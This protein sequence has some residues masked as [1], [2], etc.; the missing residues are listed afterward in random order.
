MPSQYALVRRPS[1]RL[2]E[3]LVSHID[4]QP[5]D[6]G[7]ALRQWET[8]VQVLCDHGWR[9]TEVAPADDCPDAAFVEDTMVV[10]RNVALIA[11]PGAAPRR[12]ETSGARAAAEA[13]G[14][15]VNEVRAPGTL[16]GGDVLKVGDTVYVGRGGRTNADGVRQ[17]RA[18]F[19]PL[20]ARV[21]AVPV[22]RVLH[23]KSAVTALP[24]GTVIGYP[25]VVDDPAVFPRFLAVPEE[26]GA[27]VLLLG[28]G[29]LLM[30]TSAPK[31]AELIADLGY[32]PVPVD[33]GEF[34]KL[35][36]CVTCLSV[37][38]RELYA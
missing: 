32:Q 19:E 38:L 18:A 9:T 25:P 4:R 7:R 29:R 35:E 36:G 14:C 15:S 10:F 37:R 12:P 30:S 22:S 21:I 34:E 3:G 33:I 17:L 27:H 11:R 23:L 1:P 16:D 26:A 24:D 28:G 2:A 20:G 8:Y 5:V 31:S 6:P 13:L